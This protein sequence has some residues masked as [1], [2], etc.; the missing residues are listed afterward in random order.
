MQIKVL[1]CL[2]RILLCQWAYI[3]CLIML[4]AR[5]SAHDYLSAYDCVLC[6][7]VCVL[8]RYPVVMSTYLGIMGRV[9]LQNSSF[10]SSLLTQIASECSQ[11]VRLHVCPSFSV[12]SAHS[13]LAITAVPVKRDSFSTR[14][15]V[16]SLKV[17][18]NC[19]WRCCQALKCR[20]ASR[21]FL[22]NLNNRGSP[23]VVALSCVSIMPKC[24][25]DRGRGRGG[26]W[27]RTTR[28]VS[29][30]DILKP[31]FFKH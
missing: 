20:V 3:F 25:D 8:Q 17:M 21:F 11:E 28:K 29:F 18:R 9:L 13:F 26:K 5:A 24:F 23:R 2:S 7:C 14:L 15:K 10:F 4:N 22:F 31:H 1:L 19:N 12:F 27:G 6:V 16:M 30:T